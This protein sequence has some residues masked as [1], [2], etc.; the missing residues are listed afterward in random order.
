MRE[1][2]ET[3]RCLSATTEPQAH[4][5]VVGDGQVA[6]GKKSE[7]VVVG[8]IEAVVDLRLK[9]IGA[10]G[11]RVLARCVHSLVLGT[12]LRCAVFPYAVVHERF[13]QKRGLF[14]RETLQHDGR[15][16]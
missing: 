16:G 10:W 7:E 9:T 12:L 15:V 13:E 8:D 4:V 5:R 11:Q 1:R 14:G 2:L 6:V 3:A